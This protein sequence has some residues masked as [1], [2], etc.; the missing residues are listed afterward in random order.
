YLD[1]FSLQ[2][3]DL[4]LGKGY[5]TWLQ[6][7]SWFNRDAVFNELVD[8]Q[9]RLFVNESRHGLFGVV[10]TDLAYQNAQV[11]MKHNHAYAILGYNPRTQHLRL[12]DPYGQ[13]D[14]IDPA[15][16]L[17]RDGRDDGIF[18]LSLRELNMYASHVALRLKT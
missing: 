5:L 1:T 17:P 9:H 18:E 13:G 2:C 4:G 3:G 14:I 16:G 7:R 8:E 12:R 10:L 15:V 6:V 11:G